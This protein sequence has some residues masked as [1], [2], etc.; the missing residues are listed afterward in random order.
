M[1]SINEIKFYE[2]LEEKLSNPE[3]SDMNNIRE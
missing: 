3:V 1:D 2:K